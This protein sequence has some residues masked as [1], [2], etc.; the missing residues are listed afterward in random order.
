[1]TN[2]PDTWRR[3]WPWNTDHELVELGKI[4]FS[5]P[6]FESIAVKVILIKENLDKLP[7]PLGKIPHSTMKALLQCYACITHAC[8]TDAT[9]KVWEF[10]DAIVRDVTLARC[11]FVGYEAKERALLLLFDKQERIQVAKA[12]SA[13][14]KYFTK[15]G[16]P[17]W[18][19]FMTPPI[20]LTE[21]QFARVDANR[22]QA[23]ERKAL[24]AAQGSKEVEATG[25]LAMPAA[26]SLTPAP[27]SESPANVIADASNT[28]KGPDNVATKSGAPP[29]EAI[30]QATDQAAGSAENVVAEKAP[31][32]IGDR[33]KLNVNKQEDLYDGCAVIVQSVPEGP[34]HG[35][36][37]LRSMSKSRLG[38]KRGR[39]KVFS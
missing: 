17:A 37:M 26:P 3:L 20:G 31:L 28:V 6:V 8:P 27:Q 33:R 16:S 30:P 32:A 1:M 39:R 22:Q 7:H 5:S 18:L 10:L 9:Q 38:R 25:N 36:V 12:M 23:V 29:D 2:Q 34:L 11:G 35:A 21:E 13:G 4:C 15:I 19:E 14:K 24:K